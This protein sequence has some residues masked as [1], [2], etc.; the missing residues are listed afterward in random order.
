MRQYARYKDTDN[1]KLAVKKIYTHEGNIY[2]CVDSFSGKEYFYNGMTGNYHTTPAE[3]TGNNKAATIRRLCL[4][5]AN[6]IRFS[7]KRTEKAR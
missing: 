4:H 7:R 5:G 2:N 6:A 3:V 1:A